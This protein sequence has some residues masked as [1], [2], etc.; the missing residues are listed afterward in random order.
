MEQNNNELQHWGVPGMKWG[1]R[2]AKTN[3]STSK[4]VKVNNK[5]KDTSSSNKKWSTK[6]KVAVGAAAAAGALAIYGAVKMSQAKMNVKDKNSGRRYV[7]NTL[8]RTIRS[9]DVPGIKFRVD[10]NTI[11]AI[12]IDAL[13]NI[14]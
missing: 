3:I 5:I 10:K 9:K 4:N 2:K 8:T 7:V 6:K 1:R 12:K 14:K 13:K 11:N